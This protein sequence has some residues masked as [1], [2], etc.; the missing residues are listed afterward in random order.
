MTMKQKL[1]LLNETTLSSEKKL[2]GLLK[3]FFF[4]KQKEMLI[5]QNILARS[6]IL[7][8]TQ[9]HLDYGLKDLASNRF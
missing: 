7:T 9:M 4:Q 8:T 2:L 3:G 1:L 6:T 5:N